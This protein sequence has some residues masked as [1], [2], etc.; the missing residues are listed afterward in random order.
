M[1]ENL[2]VYITWLFALTT[3]ATVIF[4]LY[5]VWETGRQKVFLLTT[6]GVLI[7]MLGLQAALAYNGFY[8]VKTMPPRF[9][10]GPV[11]TIVVL[12]ILFYVFTRKGVSVRSL[13]ILTLL[14]VIRVPVEI[15]LLWLHR[16]GQIPQLMT[17]EGINFDIL[18]GLTAPIVA[19]LAFRGGAAVNRPLLIAWNLLALGLLLIIVISAILSLES[20]FQQLAF[21]QPNRAVLYFPFIWLP[22]IVVPIVSVSHIVS[23]R[24]LLKRPQ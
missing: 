16:E 3:I 13:Q 2:P 24:Q 8:L 19:W 4:Y 23:L 1:I 20:P 15:V 10:F 22:A 9:L 6:A 14:S 18:S 7:L 17:F 21:D 5:A 12:L 11:P